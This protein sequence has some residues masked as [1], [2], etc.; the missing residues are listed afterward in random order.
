MKSHIP[1]RHILVFLTFMMTMMSVSP[2]SAIMFTEKGSDITVSDL[3]EMTNSSAPSGDPVRVVYFY[4]PDCESCQEAEKF[5]ET[6][7]AGH[8]EVSIEKFNIYNES[9][10]IDQFNEYKTKF[11]RETLYVPVVF[12]GQAGLEGSAD[13]SAHFEELYQ[14]YNISTMN[15]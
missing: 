13:I 14:W 6:Y 11:N 2:V 5:F 15:T 7:L 1:L 10:E 12:I 4:D 9:G 8:S 3:Y